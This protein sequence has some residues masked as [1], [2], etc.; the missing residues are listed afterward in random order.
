MTPRLT[1]SPGRAANYGWFRNDGTPIQPLGLAHNLHHVDYSQVMR[2]VRRDVIV[3]GQVRDIQEVARDPELAPLLSNEGVI[4]SWR[5]PGAQPAPPLV[6]PV[7]TS[8]DPSTWRT[9]ELGMRGTDVG[10]WQRQLM[11]DGY[12]LSPWNDDGIFGKGT[13]NA[14]VSWQRERGLAADGVVGPRTRAAIGTR[15]LPRPDPILDQIAFVQ[16]RHFSV[17]NRTSVDV[18]VLHT[19]EAAETS[20]TAENVARWA[21]GLDAPNTSWH[22]AIDDESIVQCVKEEHVAWAAPSRNSNGIQLEHA[23][24][25]RQTVEQWND[26]FSSR[27]LALSA[28]LAARICARWSIPM[29]FVDADALMRSERGITTH[30]EVTKG[31]GKGLT[32]HTDPGPYFPIERYLEMVREAGDG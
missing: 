25:A 20:T 21:A 22:Y 31:P 4:M 11:R 27:M 9:L 17:A 13:H 15:P 2:L 24:Y 26:P 18:V 32:S 5:Q 19:V 3:D 7:D 14:T 23:G 10:G 6:D 29:R 8:D 1:T 16:A 30:A 12:D 28:R